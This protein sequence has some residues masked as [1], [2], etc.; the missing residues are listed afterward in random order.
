MA[1]N[2]FWQEF[3]LSGHSFCYGS[4]AWSS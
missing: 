4:Q 2:W 1:P 3:V